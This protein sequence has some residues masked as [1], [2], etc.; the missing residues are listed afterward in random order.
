MNIDLSTLGVVL[1][2]THLIQVAVFLLQYKVSERNLGVGWF[3]LWSIAE[4]VGFTA[5]GFRAAPS[6]ETYAI[7]VQN[8]SIFYGT[9]CIYI[10]LF[11]FFAKK[12]PWKPVVAVSS[13]FVLVFAFFVYVRDDPFM[14]SVIFNGSMACISFLTVYLLLSSRTP[15]I[16]KSVI[17]NASV[18]FAHGLI[19]GVR[20]VLFFLGAPVTDFF[21]P[22][23]FNYIPY[24][25]G[26]VVS[27]LWTFGFIIMINQRLG[28]E[29]RQDRINLELIFDTS[30]DAVLISRLRDGVI[31]RVNAGFTA[32]TGFSGAEAIGKKVIEIGLWL[33]EGERKKLLQ[34]LEG[35]RSFS[36]REFGFRRKDG[37]LFTA[38]VSAK[39]IQLK[40]EEHIISVTHDITLRKLAEERVSGLLAEKELIL[41][42]V[43]HRIKNNMTTIKGLL[44]LQAHTLADPAAVRALGD[45][46]SR[47]QSMALLY[48]VLYRAPDFRRIS[49][50]MYLP[51]LIDEIMGSMETGTAVRTE[52]HIDDID[53]N[54]ETIQPLGIILN[55]LLTNIMKYAFEGRTAGLVTVSASLDAAGGRVILIIED[56]GNG[57]PET[58]DF[59]HSTG[60]GLVLV[61]ELTRQIGGAI[62]IERI[63]GTRIILEFPC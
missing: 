30:P 6:L 28:S 16:A 36:N 34:A 51:S 40:G 5:M 14:R 19:F 52:K 17:F 43:H 54:V 10:G 15:S 38:I 11:C 50:A 9:L 45:A 12:I 58:V 57:M 53:L 20:T 55:E 41:K 49:L 39:I 42:E 4:V 61:H 46:E 13:A 35:T 18:F 33:N 26:L 59:G 47:V 8:T 21:K 22:T 7:F 62:R 24:L 23:A 3:L 1:A 60:F 44:A 32:L 27:L 29:T 63:N 25:D 48:D 2:I 56:D 31:V 37:T